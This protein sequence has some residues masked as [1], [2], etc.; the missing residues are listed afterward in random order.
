[1]KADAE[2]EADF[3]RHEGEG[4][5]KG[6][7]GLGGGWSEMVSWEFG[8]LLFWGVPAWVQLG[9]SIP[10]MGALTE[11]KWSPEGPQSGAT[12]ISKLNR[13]NLDCFRLV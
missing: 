12:S 13:L 2:A 10:Q 1:M 7:G 3:G 8:V 4:G 9:P 11:K 6:E 5:G